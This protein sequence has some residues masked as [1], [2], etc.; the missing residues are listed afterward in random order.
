V[1]IFEQFSHPLRK[2]PSEAAEQPVTQQETALKMTWVENPQPE[3]PIDADEQGLLRLAQSGS[4]QA[5]E[6]LYALLSEP[7]LRFIRRIVGYG[8]EADDM[9][10]E[11][12]V[13]LFVHLPEIQAER[14]RPYA[15]RIARNR[16]YDLLR[17]EGRAD[18]LA[19]DAEPDNGAAPLELADERVEAPENAVYWLLLHV[20]VQDALDRLPPSQRQTL[21]LYTESELT[22]Q[23]IA[24]VMDVSTGTVKSRLFHAKKNLRGLLRP[25][26]LLALYDEFGSDD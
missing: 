16:C 18:M 9:L 13:A 24:E 20:E 5:F 6:A 12:F 15:F 17:R 2:S 22:Y 23:E 21:A 1:L 4:L 7:L 8:Q 3:T 10:Q 11:T 25:Q 19:L 14:L 26:T